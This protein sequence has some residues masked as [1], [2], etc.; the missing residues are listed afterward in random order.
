M[1]NYQGSASTALSLINKFGR[2]IQHVS[3]VEGVY[4]VAT[5]AVV[6]TEVTTNVFACDFALE[7]NKYSQATVQSGDRYALI[8]QFSG[9]IDVSDRLII[10]GVRW[11]IVGVKK[12]APAGVVVLWTV[13]IRK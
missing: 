6:N 3:I 9:V 12:L 1:F 13:H 11:S 7:D 4:N 10:D 2:T 8:G 5:S